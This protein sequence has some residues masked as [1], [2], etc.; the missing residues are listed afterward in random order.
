MVE[1]FIDYA[2]AGAANQAA[3]LAIAQ[4][5]AG[6]PGD[7][8]IADLLVPAQRHVGELWYR[9]ELSV[10]DEHLVTNATTSALYA[11]AREAGPETGGDLVVVACAEGDWHAVAAQMF[12]GALRSRGLRTTFLGASTPAEHVARF[13]E[14]QRPAAL[15]V[16]CSLPLHFS[17][18]ARLADAA[19]GAG[20]PVLTGGRA[21]QSGPRRAQ[22]LGADGWATDVDGAIELL[23]SWRLRAPSIRTTATSLNMAALEL[24]VRAGELAGAAFDGLAER[25]PA[26]AS[27]DARQLTRTRESLVYIVQFVAA[28]QLVDDV[29][30]LTEFLAWLVGLLGVRGV[31]RHA[32]VASLGLL[33]P[34][35]DQV[36][37][38][39]GSLGN[40]G[41]RY[42]APGL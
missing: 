28:A 41:L 9:N 6:V 15:A 38:D 30:V 37:A 35:L 1:D 3:E 24:D 40:A 29:G 34:L 22:L 16:S 10:A 4:L 25:F 14:R 26:M 11:L 32:V 18:V 8:V 21:L 19:H 33:S 2:L 31:Q 20:V 36:S 17:G 12:A 7:V 13:L 42:L 23:R 27:Y 5:D 39:A